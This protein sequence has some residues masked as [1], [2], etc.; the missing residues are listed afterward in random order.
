METL[1]KNKTKTTMETERKHTIE[2]A[3]AEVKAVS[4]HQERKRKEEDELER[5]LIKEHLENNTIIKPSVMY[6]LE[7]GK[8]SGTFFIALKSMMKDYFDGKA[9]AE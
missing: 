4:E 9:V 1:F 3:I 7:S 8:V 5:N 2:D 6:F